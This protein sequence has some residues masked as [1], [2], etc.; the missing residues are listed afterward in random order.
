MSLFIKI[1]TKI[2][3]VVAKRYPRLFAWLLRYKSAAKFFMSGPFAGLLDLLLLFIFH[4]LLNIS[5][6]WSTSIAYVISFSIN[7]YL[8]KFWTFCNHNKE[9]VYRQLFA[10]FFFA[11]LNLNLNGYLMHI[12]VN[13]YQMW[14]LSAQI[15]ASAIIGI[16][17]FMV[18][19]FIVFR[20]HHDDEC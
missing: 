5:V 11:F 1:V 16:D 7:F 4:G 15:I 3:L 8:Q 14:Y 2:K 20:K 13:Q 18:Y 6:L 12:L 9:H 19:K 17:S 10:Y